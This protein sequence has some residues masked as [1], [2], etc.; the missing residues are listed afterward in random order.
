MAWA[1]LADKKNVQTSETSFRLFIPK[2]LNLRNASTYS[3]KNELKKGIRHFG[4]C[5]KHRC[6][7]KKTPVPRRCRWQPPSGTKRPRQIR[8]TDRQADLRSRTFRNKLKI[9]YPDRGNSRKL[10]WI[11]FFQTRLLTTS[12]QM[13]G[14]KC[15]CVFPQLAFWSKAIKKSVYHFPACPFLIKISNISC[16]GLQTSREHL[17]Y[18]HVLSQ[19]CPRSVSTT[20]VDTSQ[21]LRRFNIGTMTSKHL[22]R[23]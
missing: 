4:M 5:I 18:C 15:W 20:F 14:L 23:G 11:F 7:R 8:Q 17:T 6:H 10:L 12:G 16:P 1:I 2:L 19:Q 3:N 13:A 22:F 9:L 21:T